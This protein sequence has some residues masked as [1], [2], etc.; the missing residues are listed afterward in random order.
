MRSTS[1]VYR[2]YLGGG[3]A[4]L[5]VIAACANSGSSGLYSGPCAATGCTDA[6]DNQND[7]TSGS[8]SGSDSGSGS[9]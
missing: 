7:A 2:W 5:G 1:F 3:L 9:A 6:G 8:G 4:C